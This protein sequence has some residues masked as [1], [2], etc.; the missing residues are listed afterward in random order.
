MSKKESKEQTRAF[1]EK[2]DEIKDK[3]LWKNFNID[4]RLEAAEFPDNKIY[5]TINIKPESARRLIAKFSLIVNDC[6]RG[7]FDGSYQCIS[8]AGF[9]V[10]KQENYVNVKIEAKPVNN[11]WKTI[12]KE[13]ESCS[14]FFTGQIVT[15]S[16]TIHFDYIEEHSTFNMTI[17]WYHI[18]DRY[19]QKYVIKQS[20]IDQE[21]EV[22]IHSFEAGK[23]HTVQ[24]KAKLKNGQETHSSDLINFT[25]PDKKT[26]QADDELIYISN[27]P[28]PSHLLDFLV[29]D[30]DT[31][32]D[33]A[34]Q[35]LDKFRER[36]LELLRLLEKEIEAR[37]QTRKI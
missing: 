4:F 23:N 11:N 3:E 24:I 29:K 6:H 30:E 18:G 35:E 8:A 1:Y 17:K 32:K 12:K 7:E 21:M 26:D 22:C 15:L 2:A 9:D 25:V 27:E 5:A 33:V 37:S 10:M 13:S 28:V 34:T 20:S 19:A 31:K 16:P 36:A 14:F